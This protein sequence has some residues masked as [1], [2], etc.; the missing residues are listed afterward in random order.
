MSV[1]P[2]RVVDLARGW[3]GTPYSHQASVK[4]VGTDCLGLIRGIWRELYG[5]EPEALPAY[6][7]DWSEPNRDEVLWRAAQ[8]HMRELA[9]NLLSPGHVILFR[10]RHGSVAKHLGV[11]TQKPSGLAFVHAYSG[12]G[13]LES[14]LTRPWLR[15]VVSCFEFPGE[16]N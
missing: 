6:T 16:A 7:K 4:G 12:R 9:P 14:S 1:E 2:D 10:M 15:R 11:V 8:C 13:V 3:L 5:G